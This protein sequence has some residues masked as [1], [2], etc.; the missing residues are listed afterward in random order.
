MSEYDDKATPKPLSPG[1]PK[2]NV[3]KKV[4]EKPK[5]KVEQKTKELTESKP[6]TPQMALDPNAEYTVIIDI[7]SATVKVGVAG[8]EKPVVFETITGAPK[9][10]NLMAD[11]S[12]MVQ[13][14]YVGDD[15]T[16]MRGVL[17]IDHPINRGTVMN[18]DQYYAILNHI[19]YN[20]LRVDPK[21]CD[22]IY[23][24]PPLTPPDIGQYY[25][26]VLFETHRCKT[27]AIIDSASCSVFSLGET[28]AL[29]FEMGAGLTHIVP[30][31]NGQLYAP[32]IQRLNLASL[33]VEEYLNALMTQYGQ[34][35]KRE[36]LKEVKEKVVEVAL[37]PNTASRDPTRNKKFL[38]PDGTKIDINA[39]VS[40]YASEILFNPGLLGY[41]CASISWAVIA[42]L[43]TVDPYYWRP[44]LK[45]IILSGGGTLLKG[46]PTRLEK[47][48]EALLPQLGPL[49]PPIEEPKPEEKPKPIET[50]L[51]DFKKEA[52][53]ML[54][55]D[56]KK[57]PEKG[58]VQIATNSQTETTNCIKCGELVKINESKFCPNCGAEVVL[59][60]IEILGAK[61]QMYPTKC[62][63]C[64]KKLDGEMRFCPECG[65]KLEAIVV[66]D[67]LDRSEQ[68]LIK[69]TTISAKE[70][71]VMT[72]EIES[73]YGTEEENQEL[74]KITE[75]PK[76]LETKPKAPSP[77]PPKPI[78]MPDPKKI[79]NVVSSEL[80]EFAAF[81]GASILG[82][83]PTFKK[84]MVDYQTFNQNPAAVVI[85]FSKIVNL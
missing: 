49:P 1:T 76:E 41:Q 36:I 78:N 9:Y 61:K 75:K 10:K 57:E 54:F 20:V 6:K 24:V 83:L 13:S 72:K 22:I 37:D 14:I 3:E 4:E 50:G 46:L 5:E 60:Q 56:V 47:E 69:K 64:A 44:L 55:G 68:K 74:A 16:R 26:R 67:K 33:D 15:C 66:T 79:V 80:Q 40:I 2:E 34:F 77:E 35:Q 48:I 42:S 84:M 30:V 17:K 51:Q 8:D 39:Y 65:E 11:V 12:G 63:K 71:K 27:V 19:F 58:L 82:S 62:P 38:M 25:A 85:D 18:W 23:L 43:R 81:K 59:K 73:E 70:M 32:S 52:E 7:G 53:K 45:R 29:A 21:K 31:M 28:T